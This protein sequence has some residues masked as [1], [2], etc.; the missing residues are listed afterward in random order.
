MLSVLAIFF[1]LGQA[2]LAS[3]Q[4]SQKQFDN[5]LKRFPEA[6]ANRDGRL[7]LE[8]AEAYRKSLQNERRSAGQK[9]NTGAGKRNFT[10]DPGWD[11]EHFPDHAVSYRS[12]EEIKAI[13]AA[14]K[15]PNQP[16]VVSFEKP[17]DGAIRIVGTGHSFMAPGYKTLPLICEAAGFTQPLY[18]HTC[19]GNTGSAR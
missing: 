5:W 13:Y 15:K 6:D 17:T 8:E 18:T 4:F 10:I 11:E 7:T 14:T 19:G 16:S 12:P 2:P 3:A 1:L 9:N